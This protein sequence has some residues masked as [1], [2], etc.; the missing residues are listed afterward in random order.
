MPTSRLFHRVAGDEGPPFTVID[1]GFE[2]TGWTITLRS[3]KADGQQYTRTATIDV[4]GDTGAGVS[5]EYHFDFL[6]ADL[7]AAGDQSFDIH[8][9]HAVD[10]DHSLPSNHKLTLRVRVQ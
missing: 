8:Y 5:A 6:A 3:T 1:E 4:V 9:A 2:T 7:A 10:A